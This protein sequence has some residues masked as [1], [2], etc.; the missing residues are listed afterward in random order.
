MRR[1]LVTGG[2][3]GIGAAIAARLRDAGMEV[4]TAD[5]ADGCDLRFDVAGDEIPEDG[6]AIAID[7][8]MGL[9]TMALT[10]PGRGDQ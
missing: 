10:R 1:A 2:A 8:G 9:N 4:L 3:R 6:E 5:V 7:G